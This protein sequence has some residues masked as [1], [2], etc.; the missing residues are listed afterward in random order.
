MTYFP[1]MDEL[2]EDRLLF[3][4]KRRHKLIGEGK[5]T[6][7]GYLVTA[8]VCKHPEFHK[9]RELPVEIAMFCDYL[10]GDNAVPKLVK[11]LTADNN[12][13]WNRVQLLE[14]RIESCRK[15]LK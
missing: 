12:R 1:D 5:C 2:S 14:S 8:E 11:A 4:I 7:C 9:K 6:Y 3:E 10:T 15:I 13:A